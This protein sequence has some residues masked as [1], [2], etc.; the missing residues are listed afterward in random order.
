VRNAKRPIRGRKN[1]SWRQAFI[2]AYMARGERRK[3]GRNLSSG[4]TTR[5][6][7]RVSTWMQRIRT[8]TRDTTRS[9]KNNESSTNARTTKISGPAEKLTPSNPHLADGD[10]KE[11]EEN[12]NN[13]M[14]LQQKQELLATDGDDEEKCE[15]QKALSH[16]G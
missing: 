16:L 3:T 11:A 10:M 5:T 2:K 15:E 12:S 8:I 6:G 13:A 1:L 9:S 7:S 14:I 4:N